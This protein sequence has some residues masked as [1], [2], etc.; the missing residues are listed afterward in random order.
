MHSQV[1]SFAETANFCVTILSFKWFEN[2]MNAYVCGNSHG[3]MKRIQF[4]KRNRLYET[5]YESTSYVVVHIILQ[6]MQL[7]ILR[8]THRFI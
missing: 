6:I 4:D 5:G 2:G 3:G 1:I 8:R 7:S